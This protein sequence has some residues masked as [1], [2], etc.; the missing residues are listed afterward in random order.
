IVLR[1]QGDHSGALDQF[2]TAA[3]LNPANAE[4]QYNLGRELNAGGDTEAAIAC[5]RRAIEL[6]PDFE[7]AHYIL[8]L[9]L[10]KQGDAG[11]SQKELDELNGLHEF[12][13]RLA[14]SKMLILQGVDTLKKQQYDEALALFQKSAEQSPELPTSYYYL[15]LTWKGKN[16]PAR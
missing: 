15:G 10:H 16:D 9:A 12:R 6:K 4:A 2:R 7:Q 11:N 14:Q 3:T 1:R 8:A 5:F 13:A